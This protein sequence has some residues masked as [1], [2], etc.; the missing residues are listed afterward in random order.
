MTSA[1]RSHRRSASHQTSMPL[2]IRTDKEN[3]SVE[4]F[5]PNDRKRDELG[6]E[7]R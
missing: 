6:L 5:A 7:V 3:K 1:P 4:R 2:K